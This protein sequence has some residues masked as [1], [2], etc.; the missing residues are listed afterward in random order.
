MPIAPSRKLLL[1]KVVDYFVVIVFLVFLMALVGVR[2]SASSGPF[3]LKLFDGTRSFLLASGVD[4]FG[5]LG[6]I[7]RLI[8]VLF[9]VYAR[10]VD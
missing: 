9:V 3:S 1:P 2:S 4:G 8:E 6:V 7:A 10:L 5:V